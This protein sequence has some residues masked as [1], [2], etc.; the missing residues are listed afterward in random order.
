M[1]NVIRIRMRKEFKSLK[2][3]TKRSENKKKTE[4]NNLR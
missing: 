4:K 1:L 3:K 2:L